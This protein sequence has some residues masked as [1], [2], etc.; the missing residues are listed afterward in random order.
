MGVL[1]SEESSIMILRP[2]TTGSV[3]NPDVVTTALK[4]AIGEADI[5]IGTHTA[6]VQIGLSTASFFQ[7]AREA[8]IASSS[9][10]NTLVEGVTMKTMVFGAS[11]ASSVEGV[12]DIQCISLSCTVGASV[13]DVVMG[14]HV[15][16]AVG[17]LTLQA[18]PQLASSS[19]STHDWQQPAS[20][21]YM[22]GTSPHIDVHDDVDGAGSTL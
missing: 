19:S 13:G 3:P 12:A 18:E 4:I 16:A 6:A 11:P 1:P 15:V 14:P 10:L 9:P 8:V 2:S 7:I 17:L 21:Q 20:S 22:H 5:A